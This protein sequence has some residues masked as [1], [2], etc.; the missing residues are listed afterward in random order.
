M[1]YMSKR[2]IVELKMNWKAKNLRKVLNKI[3]PEEF[4]EIFGVLNEVKTRNLIHNRSVNFGTLR[5]GKSLIDLVLDKDLEDGWLYILNIPYTITINSSYKRVEYPLWVIEN[6]DV[7]LKQREDLYEKLGYKGKYERWEDKKNRKM[8]INEIEWWERTI[9]YLTEDDNLEKIKEFH[10]NNDLIKYFNKRG[11]VSVLSKEISLMRHRRRKML[12][13]FYRFTNIKIGI[14]EFD[15]EIDVELDKKFTENVGV[16]LVGKTHRTYN[17]DK[18]KREVK[19]LEFLEELYQE[20]NKKI[21]DEEVENT[22]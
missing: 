15:G 19:L 20:V 5:T 14:D 12:E 9:Y 6:K 2:D 4:I 21:N 17:W 16:T 22:L 1:E 11:L 18:I 13:E 10:T 8:K 3:T 7:W